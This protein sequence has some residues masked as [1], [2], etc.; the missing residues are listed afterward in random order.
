MLRLMIATG[1]ALMVATSAQGMTPAP[2]P[3]LDD[4]VTQVAV[5]CGPGRTRV[6]MAY[7]W[8]GPRFARP[9][10]PSAGACDIRP[11]FAQP[12]SERQRTGVR[13]TIVGR[14]S[15]CS[16]NSPTRVGGQ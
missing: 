1:F 7:A 13:S 9:A 14:Q 8:R 10:G 2:L 3:Q 12:T 6:E 16:S 5:G 11:A 4:M 15:P